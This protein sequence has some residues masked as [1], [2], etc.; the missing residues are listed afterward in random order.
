MAD[1]TFFERFLAG[2]VAG[3]AELVVMY[4]T[5]V[6]KT[7]AQIATGATP[8]LFQVFKSF[9]FLFPAYIHT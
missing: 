5:D 6:I 1:L 9:N 7:R 8:P 4:P 2:G 3:L